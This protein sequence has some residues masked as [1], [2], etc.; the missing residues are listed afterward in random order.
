MK[1][2]EIFNK[3]FENGISYQEYAKKSDKHVERMK[4]SWSISEK[5]VKKLSQA[6][7]SRLNEKLHILCIAEN[8]CGDCANGVPIIARL[9]EEADHWDFRIVSRDN[10]REEVDMFYTSAGRKKIPIII[11]ADED[12]DEIIRWIERPTRSYHLLGKLRDQNLSKE[13]FIE[14]YNAL[15]ELKPPIVSQE[16][17][18][19]LLLVADKASSIVHLNPPKKKPKIL[20]H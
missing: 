10:F 4:D 9:A 11:F 15:H 7:I 3:M 16:I 8:W 12:G 1:K 13:E 17:L 20:I 18:R 2:R 19:E 5:E 6:Q 14:Q